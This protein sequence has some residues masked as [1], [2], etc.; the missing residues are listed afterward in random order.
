MA[1]T[2]RVWWVTNPRPGVQPG[3]YLIDDSGQARYLI[4]PG[5]GGRLTQD[6]LR[7]ADPEVQ[8]AA[9]PAVRHA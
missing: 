7:D 2:Y 3:K 4:D 5:I 6:R 1:K 8:P 9:A